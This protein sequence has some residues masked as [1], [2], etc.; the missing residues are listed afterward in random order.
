MKKLGKITLSRKY[1]VLSENEMKRVVGGSDSGSGSDIDKCIGQIYFTCY[2]GPENEL[3]YTRLCAS[4]ASGAQSKYCSM[5]G[6]G[7]D[8]LKKVICT[9]D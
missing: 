5:E 1:D 4:N 8:C 7:E 9:T 6:R 3:F 2:E